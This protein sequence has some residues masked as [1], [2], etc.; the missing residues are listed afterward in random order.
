MKTI[1]VRLTDEQAAKLE[2]LKGLLGERTA[3]KALM[4]ALDTAIAIEALKIYQPPSSVSVAD[5]MKNAIAAGR[6]GRVNVQLTEHGPSP[7]TIRDMVRMLRD[8]FDTDEIARK[9]NRTRG[10][11]KRRQP[12]GSLWTGDAVADWLTRDLAL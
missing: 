4:A 1:T 7:S 3:S 9:L 11:N 12:D 10:M 8:G 6:Q 5:R 2:R